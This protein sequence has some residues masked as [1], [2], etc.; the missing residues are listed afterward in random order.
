MAFY[1]IEEDGETVTEYDGAWEFYRIK[2][3][4]VNK[5]P[6]VERMFAV[7][8]DENAYIHIDANT[9]RYVYNYCGNLIEF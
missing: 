6:Y 3:A 9:G 7:H 8:P 1:Y 5:P 2:G 4:D